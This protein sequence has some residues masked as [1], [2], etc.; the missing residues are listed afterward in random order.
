MD[1][2]QSLD[3]QAFCYVANEMTEDEIRAFELRMS[4]DQSAREAVAAAYE[5]TRCV[6]AV[7]AER[8]AAASV[9]NAALPQ[10]ATD[11]FSWTRNQ[12]GMILGTAACWGLLMMMWG[13]PRPESG[14]QAVPSSSWDPAVAGQLA[15]IWSESH[16]PLDDPLWPPE[17]LDETTDEDLPVARADPSAEENPQAVW[18]EAAVFGLADDTTTGG[19]AD[20]LDGAL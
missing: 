17:Q 19:D 8:H 4:E 1:N 18:I 12:V 2:E 20:P 10:S 7:E 14:V 6:H 13:F 16:M 11:R 5:L 15:V 9:A 3:W